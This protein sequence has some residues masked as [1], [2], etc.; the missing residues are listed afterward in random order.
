MNHANKRSHWALCART[1]VAGK[2]LI[3]WTS[4]GGGT[5]VVGATRAHLQ[6]SIALEFFHLI[7]TNCPYG[8]P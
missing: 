2:Y 3:E 6:E 1:V 4:A 7:E 8:S 5:A